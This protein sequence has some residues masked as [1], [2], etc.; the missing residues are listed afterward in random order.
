MFSFV[1]NSLILSA[2]MSADYVFLK[3]T[4][5]GFFFFFFWNDKIK[6]FLEQQK[7]RNTDVVLLC[8]L[9]TLQRV[10]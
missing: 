4:W 5:D 6:L 8:V 3:W 2:K 1:I 10:K 9:K 7:T